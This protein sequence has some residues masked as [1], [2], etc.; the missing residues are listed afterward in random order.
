MCNFKEIGLTLKK[1][2]PGGVPTINGTYLMIGR[3]AISCNGDIPW[4]PRST[5][6][7][8]LKIQVYRTHPETIAELKRRIEQETASMPLDMLHQ[9]VQNFHNWLSEC[10]QRNGC[11]L[12]DIK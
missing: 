1:K 7:R 3:Y 11:Y 10:V 2:S 12:Q 5:D 9:A 6:L 8:H 4:P